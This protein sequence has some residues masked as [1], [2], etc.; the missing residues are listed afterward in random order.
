M[1]K[2]ILL[3]GNFHISGAFSHDTVLLYFFDYVMDK[4]NR[5]AFNYVSGAFP[6]KWNSGRIINT[7]S[8]EYIEDCLDE[9]LKRNI[10]IY[11]TFSNYLLKPKDL[12]DE[13]CNKILNFINERHYGVIVSSELLL[14]HVRKNYKNIKVIASILCSVNASIPRNLEFYKQ[15][16][17]KYDCVVIHPDDTLDENIIRN[18]SNRNNY[19]ILLN[20]ECSLNCLYR[21]IHDDIIS[22]YYL[23][24]ERISKQDIIN[25]ERNNC[26]TQKRDFIFNSKCSLSSQQINHLI[27]LGYKNFK[28]QG[29]SNSPVMFLYDLCKYIILEEYQ[30]TIF[31]D[32][33][34]K[35]IFKPNH[36]KLKIWK[37]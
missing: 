29:R 5:R 6:C 16:E 10:D 8:N 11:F 35:F 33:S 34:Q 28:I 26:P 31:H 4:L 3:N 22:M 25:F 1:D 24:N 15:L 17:Q 2:N 27:E 14:E 32:V 37:V 9:Y 20:E 19:E 30:R 13:E 23:Q 18:I 12:L 21:K 36:S 7:C